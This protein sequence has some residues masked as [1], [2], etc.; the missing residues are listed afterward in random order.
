[1]KKLLTV[2]LFVF[3]L[4]SCSGWFFQASPYN[5]PTPFLPP[6]R[7][8]SIVSPTP[9]ISGV[10]SPTPAQA[11][12]TAT[13]VTPA[14]VFT[15]TPFVPPTFTDTPFP[16]VTAPVLVLSVGIEVLGCDTSIDISHGLGEVTNAFI[17]L[18]NNGTLDVTNL[19]ATLFA[20]D[21]GQEHPDKTVEIPFIPVAHKV[22]VKLT[23]DSTYQAE[24]PIQVEV[25]AD[26]GL[27]QRVG[28]ESCRD[29]GLF[30]PDPG[31]LNTPV[32]V[33]P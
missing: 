10:A 11:T 28:Q 29:I 33:I 9:I 16:T 13:V 23:V 3:P 17:S 12:T 4:T 2:F 8:P 25:S 1:M 18:M 20:L 27:F 19:R 24:T 26:G 21:E 14:V 30:A 7:T 6:T 31:S 15:N 22:I 32:P 5:P